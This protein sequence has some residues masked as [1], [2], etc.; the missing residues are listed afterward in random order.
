MRVLWVNPVGTPR[1]DEMMAETLAAAARP[2]TRGTVVSYAPGT[3]PEHLEFD[4]FE[5]MAVPQL[6][7]TACHERE[8][9]DVMVIGCFYDTA[10]E[11]AREVSGE[12]I[13]TGPCTAALSFAGALAGR[14]S[15]LAGTSKSAAHIRPRITGYGA[16][17]QLASIR[18][19]GQLPPEMRADPALTEG[20]IRTEARAAVEEDGAEAIA[21]GCTLEI[22]AALRLGDT[23]GVP[24]IDAVRAPLGHA[25]MLAHGK[26]SFGWLPG[27]AGAA[28]APPAAE[29][30]GAL[31]P[32]DIA[33]RVDF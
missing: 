5:A 30:A 15:V 3:V 26:A 1:D 17:G 14:F 11:A 28:A 12:M 27:R 4:A 13:V 29:I 19:L 6:V 25:E 7:R 32:P 8:N 2:G 10:L 33:N 21:L 23:L 20:R 16:A 31:A 18:T 22:E 24:V 9:F